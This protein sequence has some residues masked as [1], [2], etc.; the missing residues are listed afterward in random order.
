VRAIAVL[1]A[2]GGRTMIANSEFTALV[3]VT[4]FH[5]AMVR[6]HSRASA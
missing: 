3:T 1:R 6:A 4:G 2:N 5:T